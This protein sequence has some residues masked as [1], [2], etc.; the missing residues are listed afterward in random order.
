MMKTKFSEENLQASVR[1]EWSYEGA[2]NLL[3]LAKRNPGPTTAFYP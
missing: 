2:Q 3:L 1:V